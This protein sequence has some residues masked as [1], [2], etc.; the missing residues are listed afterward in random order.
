MLIIISYNIRGITTGVKQGLLRSWLNTTPHDIVLLQELHFTKIK[1]LDGFKSSFFDYNIVCSMGTW[2]AGGTLIMLKKKY[3]II[4]SGIDADGRIASIKILHNQI[5]IV[6]VSIYAPAQITERCAVFADLHLYIPSAEWILIGGDFNCSPNNHNDRNQHG[7][8]CDMRSYPILLKEMIN[9]LCLGELF[10]VKHPRMV[11][12]SYHDTSRNYH[13][14][15][16]LYFGSR[17]IQKNTKEIYYAP[18]GLSDHDCLVIKLN[19]PT[20]NEEV[21]RRWISNPK[22]IKRKSFQEKFQSMWNVFLQLDNFNSTHWWKDFKTSLTFLLQEEEKQIN[23]EMR[24]QLSQ[25]QAEYRSRA[26]DPTDDDLLQ[27]DI[28]RKDIR[29]LLEEKINN[30][31]PNAQ[32]QNI[33]QLSYLAKSRFVHSKANQSKI[34]F[35]DDPT[36]GQV[37]T[38]SDMINTATRFYQELYSSKPIDVMCWNEI[39]NDI[40]TLT[41]TDREALDRDVTCSE[42]YEAL[43]TMPLGRAPGDDGITV[44]IWRWIFPVIGEHYIHMINLAKVNGQFEHG[45]LNA[46]LILL[47]KGDTNNGS[48]KNFRPLSLMNIDY[49]ILS[50]V[51]SLRLRKVLHNIIHDNQTCGIPGRTIQDNVHIFRS[52]I[53]HYSRMRQPIGIVQ[54]DQEKAFDRVNHE[55]LFE[56][57]KRCGFGLHFINWIKLLYTNATFRIKINNGISGTIPFESGVRQGCSLSGNL[58][59]ICLEPLLHN[60]RRNSRIPGVIPP[61]GQFPAV[62]KSIFKDHSTNIII[63]LS[64]YADDVTT[65]VFN[66]DDESATKSTFQLYNQAS[67]AKTN[68]DKTLILWCS[69]WLDPPS[70][71]SKV[72]R[73]WCS[74][75]VV[76]IDTTG[77]LPPTEVTKIVSDIRKQ[78][79]LW[80]SI[81]TSLFERAIILKS[82]ICSRL[83]YILSL[84]PVSN[85]LIVNLQK[86]IDNYFWN[87]KRPCIRFRTCIGKRDDGG[88]G[89]IHLK[90]MITS[91]RIKCGLK[92]IDSV[93]KLW[94][95]YAFQHAD[96]TLRS[97]APWIWSNLVPHFNDI[98]SFFGD[99]TAETSRCFKEGG[100][101]LINNVDQSIYWY[102]IYRRLFQQPICY[103]RISH[104]KNIPFFKIMH[105]CR[106]SKTATEFWFLLA[107][108][109]INTRDRLGTNIEEKRCFYCDLP[110]TTSHLF[111]KCPF[112]NQVYLMLTDH[113][114]RISDL[115]ITREEDT[116]IYLKSIS[117]ISSPTTQRQIAFLI[118]NYLHVIWRFRMVTFFKGNVKV[119]SSCIQMFNAS[120]R[121]IPYDNG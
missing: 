1:H 3:H 89:L 78:S 10:R 27:M 115:S 80:K 73:K 34:N 15:I 92:M 98:T 33:K 41:N 13:S 66:S 104:L 111:I 46:L 55:Y 117:Q 53:E 64:A 88:L 37:N 101:T 67:G 59:V 120:L 48:M 109:A 56:S 30:V 42:C 106:L 2:S 52:I 61:G 97:Y 108:Y 35:L 8:Q 5:P 16:D 102:L 91:L 39:F 116:I 58:F 110:E 31:L 79:G 63:K 45:F 83:I 100:H 68:E 40:P 81:K 119:L 93:P 4:D 84:M 47:K 54:W 51:L 38:N 29:M 6:I 19:I 49:K 18:V 96:L 85:K 24:Y 94:K 57:L 12:Y 28:I 107:N 26:N 60:I 50:K 118:G 36:K 82:L 86:E 76:P 113:V 65:I 20:S 7:I 70:F 22:V 11:T 25:L 75:L 71:Q 23:H 90:T 62:V 103:Q 44:E 69:D 95:F 14:R 99:T 21:F 121:N 72:D 112:F 105:N 17:I 77:R 9:P 87:K 74:F 32:E 114:R 43:K